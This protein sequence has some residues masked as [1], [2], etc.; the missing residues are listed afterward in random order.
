M[1]QVT[2]VSQLPK[3]VVGTA[4]PSH[5]EPTW[6]IANAGETVPVFVCGTFHSCNQKKTLHLS[7]PPF[8]GDFM[9]RVFLVLS[10]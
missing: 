9:S 3:T 4:S 5:G 2:K 8:R 7:E 1:A 6:K 10:E